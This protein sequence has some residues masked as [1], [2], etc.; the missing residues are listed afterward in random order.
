MK[1]M[2]KR[3]SFV[4]ELARHP[5]M[6][7]HAVHDRSTAKEMASHRVGRLWKIRSIEVDEQVTGSGAAAVADG[8]AGSGKES[9]RGDELGND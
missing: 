7:W 2:D 8:A 6:S 1:V 5:G 9:G 4:V 3:G